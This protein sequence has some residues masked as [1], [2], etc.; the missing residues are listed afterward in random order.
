MWK[1]KLIEIVKDFKHPAWGF[2]HFTRVYELSLELAKAQEA[3]VDD[4]ALYAAAYLHDIGAFEPFRQEGRDHSDI[5]IENCDEILK[6]IDF[7]SGKVPLVKEIIKSHIFYAKLGESIESK[8]FHDAD[9]LDF[10]GMIGITRILSI[11]GKADWTPNVK[12]A[13]NLIEKFSNDLPKNLHT[14]PAKEIGKVRQKEMIEYLE[15][16]GHETNK[17]DLI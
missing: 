5:A 4:E 7:P 9:T 12:S 2:T 8:I 13:I 16:L 6:S 15:K 11:V 10:L 14:D 17:L 3:E 1:D